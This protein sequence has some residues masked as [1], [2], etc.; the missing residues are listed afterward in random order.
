MSA[1]PE[2]RTLTLI[3]VAA[4]GALSGTIFLPSLPHMAEAFGVSYGT[5]QIAV[6]GYMLVSVPVQ[7]AVGPLS[8]RYGRRPVLVGILAL[9]AL[10]SLGTLM[11][12]SAALFLAC[13][14]LQ[15]AV[16]SSM[17]LVRA[18]I[19]DT[20]DTAGTA[21]RTGYVTFGMAAVPMLGPL[22]GGALEERFG[23]LGPAAL[24]AVLGLGVLALVW[25]DLPE[26]HPNP[27][28]GSARALLSEAPLLVRDRRFWGYALSAAFGSAAF[29]A[30]VGGGALVAADLFGLTPTATGVALGAPSLGYALGNYLSGRFALRLG[31]DRLA[32]WGGIVATV[33]LGASLA[34]TLVWGATPE[35]L[36]GFCIL[37]GIGNGLAL[38]ATMA[39]AV[40]IAP[41]LA[42]TASGLSSALLTGMGAA[43]AWGA[44]SAVE[45]SG[46]A[47]PLQAI[48]A[49][50]AALSLLS[51]GL[52]RGR[53]L[54]Q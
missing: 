19:R 7:L 2:A 28:A 50:A 18:V 1:R 8:D 32:A 21:S 46:A 22:A 13:R 9:F 44:A 33:G 26:T 38:P 52:T 36:F 42:G 39:G 30:L 24:L 35:A 17:T 45:A 6:A 37:L 3:L 53:A 25:A 4:L 48:M 15:A 51:L 41:H 49:G 16:A 5:M 11:A 43:A 47:W 27:G 40:S 34:V 20:S 12:A 29:F 14:L 10:A 23:F 54:R 31:I